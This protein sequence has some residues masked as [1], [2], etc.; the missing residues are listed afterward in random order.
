M[1]VPYGANGWQLC[2]GCYGVAFALRLMWP[3]LT[4]ASESVRLFG[5]GPIGATGV[6][7]RLAGAVILAHALAAIASLFVFAGRSYWCPMICSLGALIWTLVGISQ[8]ALALGHGIALPVWG[9]FE[10]LGGLGYSAATV[11]RARDPVLQ[12]ET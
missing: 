8:T 10:T 5:A 11:Q 12:P 7:T 3:A 9:I 2:M 4:G 1:R 6:D